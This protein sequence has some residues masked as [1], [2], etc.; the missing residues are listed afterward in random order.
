MARTRRVIAALALVLGAGLG[1]A[2]CSALAPRGPGGPRL[3]AHRGV[4]QPFSRE[5]LDRDTCTAAQ[6]LPADHTLLENTVPSMR[7]A[8]AAGA[9]VVELDVHPTAD[10]QLAVFHDWTVDCRTD[11]TGPVRAHT[12]AALRALDLG[13]GTTTDGGQ[14]FP[15]RGTGVGLMPTLPEV[16][17]ALPTGRFLV[18]IKSRDT[19]EIDLMKAFL[20]E[21]PEHRDQ[22]WGVY[23]D[24]VPVAAAGRHW[25]GLAR[26]S[27]ATIKAC[28]RDYALWGWTGHVPAACHNTVMV[29]PVNLAGLAW[30]WPHRFTARMRSVGTE[31]ILIGPYARGD[32]GTS[33]IDDP[34]LAAEVPEG[35]DGWVWTNRIEIIGPLLAGH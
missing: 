21:H 28:A 22:V 9:E 25:P 10:G 34:A 2:N 8:F 4:H 7:A 26:Y 32:A 1:A 13:H 31:V 23:G 11:G 24:P 16:L 18:N 3:L 20:D 17:A 6:S 35:F 15:L 29:V 12:M 30:G 19:R 33:G 5:G 14:S 27:K